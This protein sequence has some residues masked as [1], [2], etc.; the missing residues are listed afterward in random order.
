MAHPP[1]LPARATPVRRHR[2]GDE[3][4]E[5]QTGVRPERLHRQKKMEIDAIWRFAAATTSIST[6][7]PTNQLEPCRH[8]GSLHK[9]A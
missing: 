6:C 4:D 9:L 1:S 3:D 2:N 8:A 7:T 5:H